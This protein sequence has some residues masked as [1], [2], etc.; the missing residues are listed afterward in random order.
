ME[1]KPTYEELVKRIEELENEVL[2][3]RQAGGN[4]KKNR[5]SLPKATDQNH[6]NTANA[7]SETPKTLQEN[8]KRYRRFIENIQEEY[9]FYSHD[10]DGSFQYVSPSIFNVLGYTTEDFKTHYSGFLTDSPIN[11]KVYEY[12]E[13]SY[14]GIQHP[15]YEAEVYDKKGNIRSL[16]ILDLPAFDNQGKVT[17]VEGI[18]HDVTDR[19]QYEN[20]IKASLKEKEILLRE[21]HHRVKN[22]MQIVSSLLELQS[23]RIKDEAYADM[24][25]ESH[26]RIKAMAVVHNK[27][28]KSRDIANIDFDEYAKDI[29][30]GLIKSYGFNENRIRL[31]IETSGVTLGLDMAIPCGLIINELATNSLKY[32]F[33]EDRKGEIKIELKPISEGEIQLRVGDDGVGMPEGMNFRNTD[34]MGLKIVTVLVEKQ[35]NGNIKLDTGK[36]TVFQMLFTKDSLKNGMFK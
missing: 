22:N 19:K 21:I 14:R 35:L 15:I 29:V 2:N 7:D 8:E 24:F 28:Y 23:A 12:T 36:G 6:T 13:L 1:Q 32:A 3:L 25:K 4:L 9:F 17:A 26:N 30:H 16:E 27:L 11:K 20:L 5:H 31:S 34:T 10:L 18:A 33:P